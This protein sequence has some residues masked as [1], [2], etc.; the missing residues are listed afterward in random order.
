MKRYIENIIMGIIICQALSGISTVHAQT[1]LKIDQR[2][3]DTIGIKV[4]E[5]QK[6]SSVWSKNYPAKII[7]PNAQMRVLTPALP[8]LVSVLYLAEGDDV[9]KGQKLAEISSSAYIEAQ[10]NYLNSLSNHALIARNHTRNT[11]LLNDGII[12]EKVFAVGRSE[13]Q[14]AE[15]FLSRSHQTLLFAGI[16]ERQIDELKTT[17]IMAK[18]MTIRAPFDGTVLKQIA[19]TGEHVDE[20]TALYH[21]GQLDPLLVE[22][23]VPFTLRY[24]LEIGNRINFEDSDIE[25]SIITI[26][27]MVHVEDQGIIVRGLV[28]TVQNKYIPGQF[29]NV[30]IEQKTDQGHFYRIPNGAVIRETEGAII[31]VKEVDGFSSKAAKIIAD[32][33]QSIVI[34]ADI[35]LGTEIAVTGVSTLKGML[36]GLGSER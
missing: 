9:I 25:S 2:Q 34:G 20:T 8:G 3:I 26:G 22:I 30:N 31:F 14:V 17:R 16:S 27:Q 24:T 10:Q 18:F 12:S 23:H 19:M 11:E 32:E 28:E 1:L 4:A 33:G 15:A 29:V 5:P 35:E 13:L 21:L 36:E 7:I 6:V